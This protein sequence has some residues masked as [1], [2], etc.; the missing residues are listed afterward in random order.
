MR[1]VIYFPKN[2]RPLPH[3]ITGLF[4]SGTR[5]PDQLL[6]GQCT[7]AKASS[8]HIATPPRLSLRMLPRPH[9]YAEPLTCYPCSQPHTQ[10]T[11]INILHASTS[12]PS[13]QNFLQHLLN[14]GKCQRCRKAERKMYCT[15]EG[16]SALTGMNSRPA[17]LQPPPHL[18]TPLSAPTTLKQIPGSFAASFLTEWDYTCLSVSWTPL[19]VPPQ[20][21]PTMHVK[22]QNRDP[23]APKGH[24]EAHQGRALGLVP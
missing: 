9:P 6:A 7:Q 8:K 23:G 15:G 11:R 4:P 14:H 13:K 5:V 20:A 17:W 12:S 16:P 19:R 24:N 3:S 2:N 10:G 18:P 22:P 1:D 21:S